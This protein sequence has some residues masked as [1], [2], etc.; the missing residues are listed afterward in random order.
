MATSVG[1][2]SC[3]NR[4]LTFGL[5]LAAIACGFK[6]ARLIDEDMVCRT[7]E[8][9]IDASGWAWSF[10]VDVIIHF[11]SIPREVGSGQ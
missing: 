4:L 10:D 1:L 5:G 8:L 9:E 3:I 7:K 11:R 2:L 6:I